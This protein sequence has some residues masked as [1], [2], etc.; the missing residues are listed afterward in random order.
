MLAKGLCFNCGEPGHL[1]RNCPKNQSVPSNRKGKPPGFA[2][3]AVHFGNSSARD[4]LSEKSDSEPPSLRSVSDS[5]DSGSDSDDDNPP[6]L[7]RPGEA[8]ETFEDRLSFWARATEEYNQASQIQDSP[9]SRRL[10]DVLGNTVAALLEFFQPYPGDHLVPWSDDR[11]EAVRFRILRPSEEHYVI[12]D[13]YFD[14]VIILPLEYVR[15]PA[16]HLMDWYARQR[17]TALGI[18]Y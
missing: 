4:A 13:S 6:G 16:F 1:S 11:R 2:T 9:R 12:E 17:S 5:S 3:H 18:E 8:D 7:V 14:E 15:V 10:G